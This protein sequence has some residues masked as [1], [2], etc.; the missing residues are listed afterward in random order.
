MRIGSG[1]MVSLRNYL[2]LTDN[3]PDTNADVWPVLSFSGANGSTGPITG[4]AAPSFDWGVMKGSTAHGYYGRQVGA[5]HM[6]SIYDQGFI[7]SGW[8]NNFIVRGDTGSAYLRGTLT[9]GSDRRVKGNINDIE[10]GLTEVLQLR[11]VTY[12]KKI[13]ERD[14]DGN[15]LSE[16]LSDVRKV[17]FV[18]QEVKSIIPEVVDGDENSENPEHGLSVEYQNM[19][20]ILTKAIQEQQELIVSLTT[21]VAELESKLNK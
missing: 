7:T 11:P 17:G 21:K 10:Y 8:T 4:I 5:I 9:Q 3:V 13:F 12:Y 6:N 16:S 15:I 20:T 2:N 18:A 1:G 14:K 19:T